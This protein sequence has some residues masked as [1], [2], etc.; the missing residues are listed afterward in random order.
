MGVTGSHSK[1]SAQMPL[2]SK[3]SIAICKCLPPSVRLTSCTLGLLRSHIITRRHDLPLI[4]HPK[5]QLRATIGFRAAVQTCLCRR[6]AGE[7]F[8]DLFFFGASFGNLAKGH[9]AVA[10][11][12]QSAYLVEYH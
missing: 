12:Q 5:R 7:I 6:M 8:G 10:H 4:V 1:S 11:R 3:L 9:K 2:D